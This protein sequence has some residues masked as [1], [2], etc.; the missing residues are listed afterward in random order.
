MTSKE[1]FRNIGKTFF[2]IVKA[3]FWNSWIRTFVCFVISFFLTM[4]VIY[5]FSGDFT[6]PFKGRY[7]DFW[8]FLFALFLLPMFM[9]V[10]LF[11]KIVQIADNTKKT[12][13]LIQKYIKNSQPL[14][15]KSVKE[16][17]SIVGEENDL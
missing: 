15:L 8:E 14:V 7:K 3:V 12:T 2:L 9:N 17:N 5:Y 6:S 13:Q 16:Q 10:F 1:I 11:I 4:F